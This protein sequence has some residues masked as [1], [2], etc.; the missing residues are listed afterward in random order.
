M[1]KTFGDFLDAPS[2]ISTTLPGVSQNSTPRL[3]DITFGVLF[4]KI[5]T[6]ETHD[7]TKR[8]ARTFVWINKKELKIK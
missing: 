4:L 3:G 7:P 1:E 2:V 8:F 5:F 6:H